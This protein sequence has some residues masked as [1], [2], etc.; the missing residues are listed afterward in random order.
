VLARI[1]FD[2]LA[3]ADLVVNAVYEGGL[4]GDVTT[5]WHS[6]FR[7]AIRG[8]RIRGETKLRRYR[9]AIVYTSGA[10]AARDVRNLHH[11]TDVQLPPPVR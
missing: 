9:L 2:Q 3:S 8:F 6:S 7:L 1:P 5:P 4:N 11:P 10:V